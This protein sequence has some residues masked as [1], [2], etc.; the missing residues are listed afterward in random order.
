MIF[1]IALIAVGLAWGLAVRS[2][3]PPWVPLLVPVA[4]AIL[5]YVL[6]HGQVEQGNRNLVIAIM[7]IIEILTLVAL[8]AGF[9]Y[10]RR[11]AP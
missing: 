8:A 11:R 3:I 2:N 7:A 1:V 9:V 10:R 4:L 6:W 5:G